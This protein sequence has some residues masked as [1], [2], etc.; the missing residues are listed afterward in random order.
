MV[1]R[2]AERISLKHYLAAKL[3]IFTAVKIQI[4]IFTLTMEAAWPSGT[5]VSS[6]IT[7]RRYAPQVHD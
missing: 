5:F 2:F 6:H 7:T 3:E 4:V 1:T